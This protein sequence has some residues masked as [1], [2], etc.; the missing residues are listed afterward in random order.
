MF[1]RFRR[2]LTLL[3]IG[4]VLLT[5]A[6][7]ALAVLLRR[8]MPW[9]KSLGEQG[10]L[11]LPPVYGMVAL[12]WPVAFQVLSVYDSQLVTSVCGQVRRLTVAIPVSVFVLGGFLYFTYREVP[13]LLV[14]YFGVL[15]WLLLALMRV[16]AVVLLGGGRGGRVSA[17][18]VF[19]IGG[20]G[21]GGG[22]GE[23][24]SREGLEA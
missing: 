21:A 1:R 3:A 16:V 15:D 12:L 20:G 7:L 14:A 4:D 17:G 11:V 8:A 6:A 5:L 24:I 10:Q 9:G 2:F 19:L 18:G 22:V 13:R 23:V